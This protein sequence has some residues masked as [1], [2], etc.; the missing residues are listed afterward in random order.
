MTNEW[1]LRAKQ[2]A[3][4]QKRKKTSEKSCEL[5]IVNSEEEKVGEHNSIQLW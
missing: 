2:P 5:W 1:C 3:R 4:Q